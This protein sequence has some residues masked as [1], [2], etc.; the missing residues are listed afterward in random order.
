MKRPNILDKVDFEGRIL[1]FERK[2]V[3]SQSEIDALEGL[4]HM[5]GK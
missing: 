1:L 2:I 4:F 5:K 3:S